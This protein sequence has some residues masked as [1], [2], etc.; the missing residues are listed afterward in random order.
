MFSS[1]SKMG[2]RQ[3]L[4]SL[5]D[6]IRIATSFGG[7]IERSETVSLAN[8]VGRRLSHNL[9]AQLDL[10]PFDQSAMDGFALSGPGRN[11]SYA[12]LA[13][14]TRAEVYSSVT[15]LLLFHLKMVN[16]CDSCF[17]VQQ[18]FATGGRKSLFVGSE[19]KLA[20]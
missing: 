7:I 9:I 15:A 1:E 18:R 12:L 17:S 11:G 5:E 13:L 3:A 6:A 20:E 2:S 14:K 8:S 10:P 16:R 4:L 19:V